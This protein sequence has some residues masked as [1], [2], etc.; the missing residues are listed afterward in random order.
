ME[1]IVRIGCPSGFWGDSAVGAIQLVERADV[2][3]LMLDY[4]AEVTMS[5]LAQARAKDESFGYARD[6]VTG[7]MSDTL[8]A[9]AA[10][11]V[12]VVTNA[13][14]VNPA[15]CARA[16]DA[17]CKKRGVKLRIATVEGDDIT[18]L[19]PASNEKA[20]LSRS[21]ESAAIALPVAW[22]NVPNT[23]PEAPPVPA[24]IALPTATNAVFGVAAS[25][26]LSNA[27][28]AALPPRT[29][30]MPWSPSPMAWSARV[31][32]GSLAISTSAALRSMAATAAPSRD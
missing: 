18:A 11:G 27:A 20:R 32:A 30:P 15:S 14:G 29:M 17:L 4:L 3:Y 19:A 1:K 23:A 21:T 2:D 31:R 25:P 5:I 26:S 10:K 9:V 28:S 8:E 13:G 6:F 12:K 22:K 16:L 24:R 7:A